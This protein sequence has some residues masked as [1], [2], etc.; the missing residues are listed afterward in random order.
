MEE[1][2]KQ[3]KEYN[4]EILTMPEVR[5]KDEGRIDKEEFTLYYRGKI[6]IDERAQDS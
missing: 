5:W 6:N 1:I 2:A 3:T 4:I